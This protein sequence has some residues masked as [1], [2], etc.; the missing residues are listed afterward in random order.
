MNKERRSEIKKASKRID[1]VVEL[2]EEYKSDIE[3][4]QMD[5]E[6]AYDNLPE[7]FQ[8]GLKGDAIQEAIDEMEDAIDEIN[9][10]IKTIEN[11]KTSLSIL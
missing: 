7:G 5:E 3:I 9:T 4:I 1:L 2:L 11:I 6:E 10:V 8:N